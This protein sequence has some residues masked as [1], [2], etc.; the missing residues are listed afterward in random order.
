[1]PTKWA[2][3]VTDDTNKLSNKLLP[4]AGSSGGVKSGQ[5]LVSPGLIVSDI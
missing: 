2:T 4:N 1:M 3:S 5:D